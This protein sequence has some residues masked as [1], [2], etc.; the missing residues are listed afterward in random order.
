MLPQLGSARLGSAKHGST[1]TG[2]AELSHSQISWLKPA[3]L[4][5]SRQLVT[6]GRIRKVNHIWYPAGLSQLKM[7]VVVYIQDFSASALAALQ[8]QALWEVGCPLAET[9]EEHSL[10]LLAGE[11]ASC[12]SSSSA[13]SLVPSSPAYAGSVCPPPVHHCSSHL[14]SSGKGNVTREH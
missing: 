3:E 2:Q 4:R 14:H 10:L 5:L 8:L 11:L 12:D 6:L 1:K 7:E 9:E 13:I